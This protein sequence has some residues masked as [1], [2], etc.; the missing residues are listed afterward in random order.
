MAF[1]PGQSGNPKGAPRRVNTA[2][3]QARKHVDEAIKTLVDLMRSEKEEMR[4]K[5]A[6]G[7]L[8]RGFGKPT[9]FVELT[10]EDGGPIITA[11]ISPSDIWLASLLGAREKE[12]SKVSLP[13]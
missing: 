7:L 3:L 6:I 2:A 13:N 12:T 5:G 10:G 8:E 11:P 9:E 1:K 4:H